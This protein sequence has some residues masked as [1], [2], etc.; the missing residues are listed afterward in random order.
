MIKFIKLFLLVLIIFNI[1]RLIIPI[2]SANIPVDN[3]N[4]KVKDI[5]NLNQIRLDNNKV[6]DLYGISINS[7]VKFDDILKKQSQIS[8]YGLNNSAPYSSPFFFIGESAIEIKKN[9]QL[10][11]KQLLLD[12]NVE[13]IKIVDNRYIVLIE[14]NNVNSL[15]LKYGYVSL[16][17]ESLVNSEYDSNLIFSENEARVSKLGIWGCTICSIYT[18]LPG[19]STS[20]V[21]ISIQIF[22]LLFLLFSFYLYNKNYSIIAMILFYLC[23]FYNVVAMTL[24]NFNSYLWFTVTSIISNILFI[25]F[26]I[27]SLVK[28]SFYNIKLGGTKIVINMILLVAFII[29]LFAGIYKIFSNNSNDTHITKY[30][31]V[32]LKRIPEGFND[33]PSGNYLEMPDDSYIQDVSNTELNRMYKVSLIDA[34]YFSASTFFTVGYG[35]ITPRGILKEIAMVEMLWGYFLQIIIFSAVASRIIKAKGNKDNTVRMLRKKYRSLWREQ[36]FKKLLNII[37]RR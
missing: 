2:A 12:K 15:L 3:E 31:F 4:Y 10:L 5:V 20:S 9:A 6:V 33:K 29:V 18:N 27:L 25:V 19:E 8:V 37:M 17:S 28:Y 22:A 30:S 13:I 34:V 36:K 35:D 14:K 11:L 1:Y 16:D 26:C 24:L 21:F 23:G 7:Y 32:T